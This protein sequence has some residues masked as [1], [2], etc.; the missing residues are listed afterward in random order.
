MR[1]DGK[2]RR[3]GMVRHHFGSAVVEEFFQ[4]ISFVSDHG[5]HIDL[6]L[7]QKAGNRLFDI[8]ALQNVEFYIIFGLEAVLELVHAM[9]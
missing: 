5:Q 4:E 2:H 3:P 9:S 1:R 6:V 7:L 8:I